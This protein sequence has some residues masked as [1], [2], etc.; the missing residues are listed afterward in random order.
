M[1]SIGQN[2]QSFLQVQL[3]NVWVAKKDTKRSS[4]TL[5]RLVS[6]FATQTLDKHAASEVENSKLVVGFQ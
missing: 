2:K 5:L 6:F 4:N 3:N 1:T